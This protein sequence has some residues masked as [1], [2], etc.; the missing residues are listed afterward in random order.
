MKRIL[1]FSVIAILI[2][3]ISLFLLPFTFK[4]KIM[5]IAQEQ[6]NQNMN[7][8]VMFNDINLSMFK[9]FPKLNIV[10]NNLNIKGVDEFEKDTLIDIKE[11]SL[12]INLASVFSD[13][14][15]INKI[16][17]QSPYIGIKILKGGKA[18]YDIVPVDSLEIEELPDE[19]ADTS[20]AFRMALQEFVIN[21]AIIIYDDIDF[22]MKAVLNNLNMSLTGDL[23]A[24][25][26]DLQ[27]ISTIED[28]TFTMEGLDYISKSVV[29]F[30]AGIFA[31]LDKF[32][33]TFKENLLNINDLKLKFEGDLDISDD[34]LIGMDLKFSSPENSFKS[35]LSLVPAIYAA[36]FEG[37]ESK[38]MFSFSGNAK[39]EMDYD[40][41]IYP[42]FLM[43]IDVK[44]GF[45]QYPDLPKSVDNVNISTKISSPGGAMDNIIVDVSQFHVEM[46]KNPMD[47]SL[48]ISHPDTDMQIS[49]KIDGVIDFSSIKE[50]VP[51]DSM[52]ISGMMKANMILGGKLSSL[53]NEQYEDF[54]A[55]GEIKLTNFEF[56]MPEIPQINIS[57]ALLLF[58]PKYV[59]LQQFNMTI[60]R[61][62]MQIKGKVENFVPYVFTDEILYGKLSINSKLFDANEF[63]TGE[64][65]AEVTEIEDDTTALEAF[66]IPENIDFVF[67]ANMKKILYDNMIIENAFGLISLNKGKMALNNFQVEMLGGDIKTTGYYEAINIEKPS[68]KFDFLMKDI[69]ISETYKTFNT[70]KTIAPIAKYSNGDISIDFSLQTNFD[71]Y[72]NPL[73]N[74]LNSTGRLYTESIG[75]ENNQL[76]ESIADKFKY[77]KLRNPSISDVDIKFEI[78][79]GN[80]EIK[81]FDAKIAGHKA[82]IGGKQNV[83]GDIDYQLNTKLPL[84][85]VTGMLAKFSGVAMS[86]E[87]DFKI[88][89]GGTLAK[90]KIA[91]IE[92]GATQSA[93][94]EVTEE[95]KEKVSEKAQQIIDDA[96]KKADDLNK[97][98]EIQADNLRKTA[99]D[100][101][102]KLIAESE[103]Q[104]KSLI[105]KAGSNPIKKKLAEE[106]AKKLKTEATKK[107]KKLEQEADA[108][109][110]L[111]IEKANQESK[112]IITNAER[113]ANSL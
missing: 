87:V 68:A 26:T 46:A 72:L 27:I 30:D 44:D 95:V 79:N 111:I 16:Y 81:P 10:I 104:G 90:P 96:K 63:L 112:Q 29:E 35:L 17:I 2:L 15:E 54:T 7:A 1:K 24:S 23:T 92:S 31:D 34:I 51:L 109:A 64:E 82:T 78:V 108:K 6:A 98:A 110:N 67:N 18:N 83:A 93:K 9:S 22:D 74:T 88:N 106:S 76:F 40:L 48:H 59:D 38:G 62:D 11:I 105:K 80:L 56:V 37:L 41:T 102:I 73:Y 113:K 5:K 77:E 70:V 32:V 66:Q 65:T 61:S 14:I 60:G 20:S 42:E 55:D 25:T 4:G 52:T 94:E 69:S 101:G 45:F 89:I 39:G 21:D 43:N 107:A 19:D 86:E 50:I 8:V 12:D 36:D 28:F 33:F 71:K 85:K 53:E 3:L 99:K 100:A 13:A 91:N 103:T 58:S 75:I 47:I 57:T 97:K 49:G 84:G